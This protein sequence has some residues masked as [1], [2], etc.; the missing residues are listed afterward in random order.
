MN[1]RIPYKWILKNQIDHSKVEYLAQKFNFPPVFVKIL[2]NR[3]YDTEDKIKRFITNDVIY[4]QNPFLFK[5]M[6][7]ALEIVK[8]HIEENNTILI[9]GDKDV[10]GITSVAL[11]VKT[12]KNF[13]ANILWYIP[14]TEGYGLNKESLNKYK[15]EIKLLITVDC[16]ISSYEEIEYIKGSN[17]DVV[18]TDHHEPDK[19]VVEKIRVLDIPIINPYLEEY[20]G[21]KDLAGVGVV[22][23]LVMALIMS[24]DIRYYNKNFVILDIETTG[25]SPFTDEICEIS[26]LRIKNFLPQEFFHTLVKPKKEIP[27]NVIN[28]HGITNEMVKD[29]PEIEEV[30]PK[31][32]DFIKDDTLVIHNADFDLSFINFALKKLNLPSISNKVEDTLIISRQYFPFMSHSL[33]SLCDDFMFQHKPTH[34]ANDDV[35]ATMELFY[36]LYH[37][38][39]PKLRIFIEEALTFASL[40]TISDL[41]PLVEDNRIIVKKGL[42]SICCS[43]LPFSKVIIEYLKNKNLENITADDISWYIIPL[44]NSAGRIKQVD[45]AVNFLL[46]ETKSEAEA[47]F[48]KLIEINNKRKILQNTN[49]SIFYELVEQQCNLKD[50]IIIFVVAENIETGVTGTIANN[51]LKEFS[52]PVVLIVVE[53]GKATGTARS[54]KTINI[55]EI[56][57]KCEYLFEKFGGHENACGFTIKKENI[58][59]LKKEI[60]N[61]EKQITLSAPTLEIDTEIKQEELNLEL[62]N[63]LNLLEPCGPENLYPIFLIK[64]L[65]VVDWKY[66]GKDN[67]YSLISFEFL[68]SKN[69]QNQRI[70]AVCWDI[71]EIG[72]ILRNFLYFNVV[73]EIEKD[74]KDKNSLRFV[75]IDLQPII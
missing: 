75:I 26:A 32:L 11:L 9:W 74:P 39:N 62:Y 23:K 10:D 61:L 35:L 51:M 59:L 24:Y 34:R 46:S 47:Y 64:N 20:K 13:G 29:A 17:I 60:K 70:N 44:L 38:S 12:L 69:H 67:K 41:M 19:N 53:N 54:P 27:Q 73:G 43:N 14:Q 36:Y 30:I 58:P 1:H 21:F 72:D 50:D 15:D 52:R 49:L 28:I 68:N 55:F 33:E 6:V 16:G 37:I 4:L 2:I 65:K 31:L 25:L 71:P 56:L 8:K 63:Y 22:L 45:V 5:D 48:E 42:E 3:G 66:I 18:I 40:G 57:K 7:K